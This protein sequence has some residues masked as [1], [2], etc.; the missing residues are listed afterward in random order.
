M[1]STQ[2]VWFALVDSKGQSYKKTRT[3]FVNV[4]PNISIG[5]FTKDVKAENPNILANIDP[6]Q[7]HVY[8]NKAAFDA[9]N[10]VPLEEDSTI[11]TFGSS[12]KEALVVVV[13]VEDLVAPAEAHAA[14]RMKMSP[15][16]RAEWFTSELTMFC[17]IELS[18]DE[19]L[20]MTYNGTFQNLSLN[21]KEMED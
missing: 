5:Q 20:A 6:A 7:L 3:T 15:V 13:P 16:P 2:D 8:A 11:G 9:E 18:L 10:P 21:D 1:A 12:K 17:S 4:S 14:K 19:W